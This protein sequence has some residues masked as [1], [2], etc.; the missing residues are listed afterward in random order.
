MQQWTHAHG[1]HWCDCVPYHSEVVVLL[2]WKNGLLKIQL[3]CL[4]GTNT[5]QDWDKFAQKAIQALKKH[6]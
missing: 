3:Q 4:L 6:P 1:I 5:F 2:E